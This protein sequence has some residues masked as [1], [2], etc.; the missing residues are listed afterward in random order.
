MDYPCLLDDAGWSERAG[1]EM[2]PAFL[3]V[4]AR[5]RLAYRHVGKLTT[6]DEA[7]RELAA[8]IERLLASS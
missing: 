2:V 5:G 4:D 3:L 8:I 7:M 6:D 1:V